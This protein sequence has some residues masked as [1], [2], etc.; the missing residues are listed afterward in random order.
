M[1][2]ANAVA[3][4]IPVSGDAGE[5]PPARSI[6]GASTAAYQEIPGLEGLAPRGQTGIGAPSAVRSGARD[7]LINS[8]QEAIGK[9]REPQAEAAEAARPS[10][11]MAAAVPT[12][13]EL[14]QIQKEILRLSTDVQVSRR[15][16]V[17]QTRGV[18]ALES[19]IRSI[20]TALQ[21]IESAPPS[22]PATVPER[23]PVDLSA[24]RRRRGELEKDIRDCKAQAR[25]IGERLPKAREDAAIRAEYRGSR[26][27]AVAQSWLLAGVPRASSGRRGGAT[28]RE[29]LA[30]MKRFFAHAR[31]AGSASQA[32]AGATR[33][34][35]GG[36]GRGDFERLMEALSGDV[37]ARDAVAFGAARWLTMKTDAAQG[38]SFWQVG[39]SSPA[40]RIVQGSVLLSAGGRTGSAF[41]AL[42]TIPE[43]ARVVDRALEHKA[44]EF[45]QLLK[46][47]AESPEDL[48]ELQAAWETRARSQ[49]QS[50]D[51]INAQ[52]RQGASVPAVDPGSRV[53]D[54]RAL[55][56]AERERV[57]TSMAGQADSYARAL[58]EHT[59]RA[60][61]LAQARARLEQA[62][63]ERA[64]EH[65]AHQRWSAGNAEA[66]LLAARA[67]KGRQDEVWKDV[68]PALG[69]A[70]SPEALKRTLERHLEL[71]DEAL[72]GRL[73]PQR[74]RATTY[75]S[76]LDL[77][78]AVAD[79]LRSEP[80]EGDRP[81]DAERIVAHGRQVGH[82]LRLMHSGPPLAAVSHAT[83]FRL[84]EDGRIAHMFPW[85]SPSQRRS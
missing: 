39:A 20:E 17:A 21:K 66:R 77:L 7:L 60:E 73:D 48:A 42:L 4:S 5:A 37:Q 3:T 24:L 69:Q 59:A 12:P 57:V 62:R 27:E 68:L 51:A 6:G 67:Q 38:S 49:R 25:S 84:D 46:P 45:L 82:G 83:S 70:F 26:K 29:A 61:L 81:V 52:L 16:L 19:Q 23:A 80:G 1:F 53:E 13:S 8:I 78:V 32:P 64:D 44:Q 75:A 11:R 76:R 22:L 65:G 15:A 41:A 85:I 55:L 14:T 63:E 28:E 35:T 74:T 2:R 34:E 36:A 79:V 30:R 9:L 18:E 50:L 54:R 40:W 58:S 71:S 33:N 47:P 43:N 31:D 72:Q 10:P 56:L